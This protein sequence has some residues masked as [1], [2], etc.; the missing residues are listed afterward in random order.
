MHSQTTAPQGRGVDLPDWWWIKTK[1]EN[2]CPLTPLEIFVMNN[3]PAG[4]DEVQFRAELQAVVAYLAAQPEPIAAEPVPW[5]AAL[6]EARM[7]LRLIDGQT[8][9]SAC[10]TLARSSS[11][12]IDRIERDHGG[13][14]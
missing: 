6:A 10:K 8:S 9:L 3:E 1:L 5:R 14:Q 11:E 12:F 2:G 13:F 4:E 7:M